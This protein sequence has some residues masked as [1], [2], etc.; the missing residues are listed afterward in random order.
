MTGNINHPKHYT[1]RNIGYECIEI[2]QYQTFL[3]GNVIKYLW[4]YKDKEHPVEDLEKARWYA[5][6]ASVMQ[7]HVD[8]TIG[9]CEAILRRLIAST[10]GYE[11]SAWTGMLL[12]DWHET[13]EALDK[14][15][16]EPE[17]ETQTD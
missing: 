12:C 8:T 4:R 15:I 11:Q 2:V 6:R 5:H 10:T 14:M 16:G 9:Y 1:D 17:N 3:V 13:L 7:E